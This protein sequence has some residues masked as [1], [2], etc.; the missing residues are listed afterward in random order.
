MSFHCKKC[1]KCCD[2]GTI[3]VNSSH[4]LIRTMYPL[5]NGELFSD[6]GR[7]AMLDN[8]NECMIHKYLGKKWKPDV[9]QEFPFE[10]GDC[11]QE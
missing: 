7:C 6:D 11:H 5:I 8:N 9:C 4:P 1:A 10:K 3:W 2:M